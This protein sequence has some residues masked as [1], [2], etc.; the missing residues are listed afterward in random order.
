MV[1][2]KWLWRLLGKDRDAIVL[3]FASGAEG[4]VRKMYEEIRTLEPLREHWVVCWRDAIAGLPCLV[5]ASWGELRRALGRRRVGL[6]PFLLGDHPLIR[7]AF[8]TAPRRLLA[9]NASGERHHL[10]ISDFIASWLFWRGLPLD[11]IWL[12]PRWWPWARER[13][14]E[15]R[16]SVTLQGRALGGRPRVAIVSPYYPWPLGHGG[17]VRIYSLL[18]EAGKE[19][20]LFLYC[21]AE[22]GAE[23]DP[24]PVMEFVHCAVL[25]EMPRYREPRWASIEPP[26]VREF[27]SAALAARMRADGIT[28]GF[29]LVQAE[30]TQLAPYTAD[31]LVEHDVTFDLYGQLLAR[32]GGAAAW[33]DWWRW[34]RFEMAA[35]R[36]VRCVVV[37]A[38][39]DA[40]LLDGARR[41][42]LANGVDLARFVPCPEPAG[43]RL[44]FVGSFRHFPNVTAMRFFFEEAW[45]LVRRAAPEAELEVVA[46]RDYLRY[47]AGAP[48]SGDSV[49]VHGFVSDVVPLYERANLVL[50]PTLVSAGTNLKVLE[51]MAM[52]RAVVSTTSGCAGLG[53]RHGES[54]W[55]GDGAAA[56]A[57]GVTTLL[58]DV[59][60]RRRLALAGRRL[61]AAEFDWKAIGRAQAEI[62]RGL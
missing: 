5:I 21:F 23:A 14:R 32:N 41:T 44:L 45:P 60:L 34:R 53:L 7:L 6:A 24:G 40:A 16:I 38:E 47:W 25:F 20:D 56:F 39:K 9:F 19:F 22:P 8:L 62:W 55:I 4:R 10:R 46:G 17:A 33:W 11:R 27:R 13:S 52:E 2:R 30:Y 61:A 54:V 59:G 3:H 26:E 57:E 42:V 12:R 1:A 15:S 48:C 36:R 50:S 18:R 43:F 35:V 31:V 49:T 28:F 58:R 37:M 51:A 29:S